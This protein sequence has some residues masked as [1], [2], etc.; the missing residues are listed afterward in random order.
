LVPAI[1]ERT[2]RVDVYQRTPQW[3][4]PN[5]AYHEAIP[6]GAK[7][8][9]RHLPYYGRWL[10][11][12]SWW[13]L[14][15]AAEERVMIDPGWD[16][17]GKSCGEVN[18]AVRDMLIAWMRAFTDDEELLEKVIPD[19]P[20]MGKRMLQ[21]NGTWLKTLQRDDVDLI[22]DG[23][24]EITRDGITTVDGVHRPADVLV[25]ATGFDVNHQLGPINIRGLD[26][27][28]LNE[29]WG[30]SAYA[31]LGVT[32]PGFPNFFC[33]YGPGTNAVNGASI[34][35]NS[36]C[37]M[38][39]IMGC[40]DMILVDGA[41]WAAPRADVCD[42]YNRRNQA[43]L[44]TMVYTHPKVVSYYKN[45]A[46][47]VPTLYGFRIVDYWKWTRSPNPDDYDLQR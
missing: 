29:A 27:L 30:E 13:P 25:W 23:I 44:K 46:G 31:Y 3:M 10:R 6:D 12:V 33:M 16:T 1:A 28:S 5:V 37:Q 11:F 40:I 41:R 38:R 22:R 15:D 24:A 4:A 8:A 17:G 32:V 42:D 36:E 43:R 26:G 20:P 45:A 19:Y 35:Y 9:I 34:I 2:D 39:Y 47:T 21:D 14:T 7:W 18:H